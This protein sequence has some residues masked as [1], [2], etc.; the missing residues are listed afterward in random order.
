MRAPTHLLSRCSRILLLA[1]LAA[2]IGRLG[3]TDVRAQV[4]AD[5]AAEL[6]LNSAR[7]AYNEQ[8]LPFAA[9]KFQ[10]FLQ[11]FGGH[12]QAN[13]AR[14]GL[15]LCFID[16]PER[17]FEKAIEPLNQLAGNTAFPDHPYAVY[18]LGLAQRGMGLNE[19]AQAAT[20]QGNEQQQLRARAEGRFN[21]AARYFAA[22]A[23]A[24][25]A[26][27]PK[28]DVPKELPK[29][30][31]W[32]ARAR[33]DQAEME[34]RV[35]KLKE[36]R[37]TSEPF[38][39]DPLLTKSRYRPLGLYYH[40]FAAFLMQDYL[41]AGRTL[42][43]LSPFTDPVFGLHARY[44]MGRVYQISEEPDKAL[45]NYD[46]V[47]ADFDRM[48]KEA[49]EKLKRPDLLKNL[50]DERARL[51]ALARK[52]PDHVAGAVFYSACLLYEAGRFG[53]ALGRFQS[54]VKEHADSPF[55]LDAAMRVGYCQVQLKQFNEAA[56]ML[57]PLVEKNPKLA[58][59]A[60]F[61]LGKAQL[62]AALAADP[63]NPQVRENGLKTA[64]ATF[65]T[66][67][68]RAAALAATDP[69]AKLRRGEILF[70][71]ADAQQ[72]AKFYKEA[73]ALLEQLRN[74]K[75]LPAREEEIAQRAI[76]AV[77]L[78]GDFA[79]SDQL[80]AAFQK[81]YPRSP[82]LPV[83]LFRAAENG[84]FAALA[85]ENKPD[86]P[87]KPVELPKLYD[88]AGK[89]YKLVLERYPEFERIALARY[90]LAM[91][92]FKKSEFEEAL[93]VL[94]A[95][96][97]PDRTGDL[98]HAAFLL[99]E[100][101]IR[102][103]PAKAEDA[104]QVGM[105]QEK[106]QQAQQNLEAFIGAN[107]K[108]AETPDAMLKLG[109]CQSRL[110]MLN[111]QP[112]E[113]FNALA[114]AQKTFDGLIQAHPTLPPGIQAVMERAKNIAYTGDKGRAINELRRFTND[115][116][117]QSA[118]APTAVLYLATLLREQNKGD[119]AANILN[120][121]RQR[122]EAHLLKDEPERAALLRYH[123]G[124]CLQE[125]NKPAEARA[126]LESIAKLVASKPLAVEALLRAGQCRLAESR[127]TIEATR[128]QLG[129]GNLKPDQ[130]ANLNNQLQ[131]NFAVLSDA[132]GWLQTRAEELRDAQ[133]ALD[134]RVRMYYEAAWAWRSLADLEVAAARSQLQVEK[135]KQLQAEADKKAAPGTKAAQVPMPAVPRAAVP[136]QPSEAKAR[137]A[138]QLLVG[139][140][141]DTLLAIESRFELAEL[142]AERDEFDPAI[143]NLKEALDKEPS[144]NK[145]PSAELLD[146]V[147]IRLGA[148]LTA[149]KDHR[150]A[151]DKLI[152]V[153]DNPKSPLVAQGQYRAAECLLELG[154][155][156][157]AI[158]RF[159]LFRDKP[160]FR[161]VGD[162][163][164]RAL[165]R[166]GHAYA[167]LKQWDAS[168]QALDLFEQRYGGSPWVNE[169]R[170]ALGWARQNLGQFDDAVKA[171]NAVIAST[172]NELAAKSHLQIGLCRLE[173]KRYGDAATSLLVVPFTFDYPDLSAAALTEAAHALIEDK[174]PE[175]AERLLRRV[176]KDYPQNEWAKVA[177]KRLDEI[178]K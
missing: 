81:E 76:T 82:L 132:A 121:A 133:P 171:Y 142:L 85:A 2:G 157:K 16:G 177:Q 80:C 93:K 155:N 13:A 113:R 111:A 95:I 90:G 99:A 56:G 165:L 154:E 173:Q 88:E 109:V 126:Q 65:K 129:A 47:L 24:F 14:Y 48:R 106:L 60:L 26:K 136:V 58:D 50:P 170:F 137:M 101:L 40:G 4:P 162:I 63:M 131:A 134:A 74:E 138:Y 59:Q 128:K 42:N 27:L 53:E 11:K 21:E 144:D 86:F 172:A 57:A 49:V 37:A 145:L 151:L 44:L 143:K 64:I 159:I 112:Q 108:S 18:Y 104:L 178:K 135:Q 20:K 107:P 123:Q 43:Q 87:N 130:R 110:A 69:D 73:A 46:G 62:G 89:R 166:L 83:V 25:S 158:A 51:E 127:A 116:L 33:C 36:A 38:T 97:A 78:A 15:A 35:N 176:I 31:D 118:V 141:A 68:D 103:A 115:P 168:R 9:T 61:W 45:A 66:A 102:L 28:G 84:Y 150:A 55:N 96:P 160:E 39:K 29:E 17:N 5:Q 167:A 100:C 7:K 139:Y 124:I 140:A 161:N 156:D 71:M 79:R 164:D 174:K 72:Q 117:Q 34:L 169:A 70:E 41:V 6:L 10:E 67:A 91:C 98:G 94:E 148:C 122:H 8:N 77:H 54:F 114:V 120:G 75:T 147:R 19:L 3:Q 152:V 52:A 163:S 12:P 32:A 125:A 119:E 30:L 22:A 175:Q 1:I 105:L 153:A 23:S 149:K 92:H 146:K